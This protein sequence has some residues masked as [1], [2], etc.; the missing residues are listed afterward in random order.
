SFQFDAQT[1]ATYQCKFTPLVGPASPTFQVTWNAAQFREISQSQATIVVGDGSFIG[2]PDPETLEG[3]GTMSG[4]LTLHLSS[5]IDVSRS[6]SFGL[7]TD[8][9]TWQH[10]RYPDGPWGIMPPE[11]LPEPDV[12]EQ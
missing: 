9:A 12:L 6:F 2:A 3:P 8:A 4:T 5:G 1:T 10:V 11:L 7:E